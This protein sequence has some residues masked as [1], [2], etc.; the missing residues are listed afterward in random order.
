M[1][2]TNT[3]ATMVTT[4]YDL[5]ATVQDLWGT[6]DAGVVTMMQHLLGSGQVTWHGSVTVCNA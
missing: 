5:I 6:D 3:S 1:S 4:L 2:A